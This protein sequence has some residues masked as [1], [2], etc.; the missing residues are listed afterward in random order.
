ML[1]RGGIPVK[2]LLILFLGIFFCCR[3]EKR[4][5]NNEGSEPVPVFQKMDDAH[6]GIDFANILQEDV[7]TRENI[8]DFDYFYNGA[9]VGVG[10]INNDGLPDVFFCGNQ[11]ANKLYLNKGDLI[12]EDI[13]E[14]AGINA[15]KGWSNGVT[16][17]DI[18]GD[19]WL[20]IYVSQGGPGDIS[21]REN[22][23]FINQQDLTFIEAASSTGL[24]DHAIS[25]QSAFFDYDQDQ[26]LDCI[27][28]N[29][30]PLYGFD[31]LSF[32][33]KLSGNREL[34]HIS[35]S[36]LYRN[37]N[38][39]F[40]DVT[41]AAGILRPA[42]GLGLVV[43]DINEDG[44]PDIYIANDYYIPDVMYIN[45]GNG[46]FEDQAKIRTQ[47][48]S[49][50]GMGADIADIN[51]DSHKDIFVLDMAAS[52]HYRS[53]TL[54]ASMDTR[55]FD[56]LVNELKYHHQYMFNALQLDNGNHRFSNIAHLTGL[57]KTDWS[58]AVL[59]ADFDN[60]ADKD[61]YITNGYRR[62]AL[63]NDT[64]MRVVQ[65]KRSYQQV[66]MEVKKR[67]Y[68]SMPTEK[69]P[70][71]MYKNDGN[72]SFSNITRSWGLN[73]PSWSN[74]AA[75]SDLDNDGDLDIVVNNMDEKA[76]VYRNT[77]VE[78]KTGGFL[79]VLARG[80][81]SESFPKITILY[82]GVKQ[83]I[84]CKRVRG[85]LSAVDQAAHFGL[86]DVD[87]VD[88]VRVNWPSGNRQE[89]YNVPA[90][91]VVEFDENEAGLHHRQ[92]G[93]E[94]TFLVELASTGTG[95]DFEHRE[96]TYD[97]FKRETLLPY[98][99]STFGPY[100]SQAD[101]NGDGKTDLYIGGASGQPGQ[102][103]IDR[104]ERYEAM[105]VKDFKN[106]AVHEDMESVFFDY[107]QD[108]DA[109]LYVISGGNEFQEGSEM[110]TDRLYTNDGAGN[111]RRS[112]NRLP[113]DLTGSG[114]AVCVLDYD[115]DGDP[116]LVIGNRIIPHHYPKASSSCI[117]ENRKGTFVNVTD[118]VLPDLHSFGIINAVIASDFDQD[119]WGD[120]VVAGEWTRVG[121]FK[122]EKGVFRDM[123]KDNDLYLNKGWWFSLT[124]TDVNRDGL[125]DFII[126]NVGLNTKYKASMDKP[127]KVFA[128]DFDQNGTFDIVLST[129]YKDRYVPFRGRECSSQQTPFIA[130]KFPTYNAFARASLMDVYGDQLNA[131]Y[132]QEATT[133]GSILLVN[134]GNARFDVQDLPVEAQFFPVMD[135]EAYDFNGDGFE[136]ILLVGGIYNTEVETPRFD[137]GTGL[138]LL[139][140][141]QGSYQPVPLGQSGFY[142]EGA[143]KSV[144]VLNNKVLVG[145]NDGP[146]VQFRI[147]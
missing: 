15:G 118:S 27:V 3:N 136:D 133:F 62:Y 95:L 24:N 109:D 2:V 81:L 110:Y 44:L 21:T 92:V 31:P 144:T 94:G 51:N 77:S 7:G 106:D 65:A 86:G 38:G 79:K 87:M 25:M 16:F 41:S 50:F 105:V 33:R 19:G 129:K 23:L 93:K 29:E 97:D 58:W 40:T 72:L 126:G 91:S 28:M 112:E 130:K 35:S 123:S 20:D 11:V 103:F 115:Q 116:D 46:T 99:Q 53:K 45:R 57:A 10:D 68:Y 147:H 90:N 83:T 69:L 37:D 6:T 101:V 122:N 132:Q 134:Q 4:I 76:F 18:N 108:G 113:A 61:V 14:Q 104:G 8:F 102:L 64:R 34:L 111:F 32:R 125:P 128:S 60:D 140:D 47:H 36:H 124:E 138:M 146:L 78:N 30:N 82:D 120:L 48:L 75:Y 145:I 127:L 142:F 71:I 141:R 100:M 80:K 12:F 73:D 55:G 85:Y 9:G 43:S 63:D 42:F 26:D 66:P 56:I 98:R 5:D 70:N 52:D 131:S 139:A 107:D 54:M 13:T 49:F 22:L 96:N 117:L 1:C 143:S 17:A 39:V 59:M 114:K 137:A 121:L 119:G 89:K 135:A 67:I 84:E 88:T 74:G